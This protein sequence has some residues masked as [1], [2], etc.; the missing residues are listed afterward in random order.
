M[1]IYSADSELAQA[2]STTESTST[3]TTMY[4]SA[5]SQWDSSNEQQAAWP[6]VAGGVLM[7]TIFLTVFMRSWRRKKSLLAQ[8][9]EQTQ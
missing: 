8:Q 3:S 4:V 7:L 9:R 6:L 2:P 1:T 5:A